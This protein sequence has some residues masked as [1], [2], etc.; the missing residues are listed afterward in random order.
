MWEAI[1]YSKESGCQYFETGQ[2]LY[3]YEITEQ[4]SEK[5]I[6]ISKFKN[7]FGGEQKSFS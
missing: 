6:N 2:T 5:E 7:G 4:I 3:P 1:K